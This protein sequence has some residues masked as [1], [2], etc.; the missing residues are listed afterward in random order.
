MRDV[1]AQ[2]RQDEFGVGGDFEV[3]GADAG[4]RDRDAANLGVV[5]A[6]NE[7]VQ[8]RRQRAVAARHLDAILVEGQRIG[9]RLDA[10]RLEACRPRHA[11]ADVLDEEVGAVIV[12]GRVFAPARQRQIAPAAVSR[13]SRRQHGGVATVGKEMRSGRRLM[14]GE[15]PA[16]A[17]RLDIAGAGGRLHFR[18]PWP[19]R[20]DVARHALLQ[21][22]FAGLDD[23]L[24]METPAHH[25]LK[26]SVGDGD[27]RHALVMRHE[28]AH[29]GDV[30]PSG[31][32]AGV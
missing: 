24:G 11:A 18:R 25:A 31:T 29:D 4:I 22:Q 28:G 3:A 19:R 6:G 15:K 20:S 27:D 16:S 1:G 10:A 8:R 5:L 9:V 2:R 14:R 32:R 12:A 13:A 21:Q 17:G 23:R 26:Q 30:S 7:H